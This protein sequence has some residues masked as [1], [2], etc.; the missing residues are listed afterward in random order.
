MPSNVEETDIDPEADEAVRPLN[1]VGAYIL[2]QQ[3]LAA[4]LEIERLAGGVQFRKRLHKVGV[5]VGPLQSRK[6][7]RQHIGGHDLIPTL[8]EDP[9]P[10]LLA[11]PH[12][13]HQE[14]V[15]AFAL[16]LVAFHHHQ[17][18]RAFAILKFRDMTQGGKAGHLLSRQK[19]S[20]APMCFSITAVISSLSGIS[21][22]S[23]NS[24]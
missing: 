13:A 18:H 19:H 6:R 7:R 2:R 17:L 11:V 10:V 21:T 1:L 8:P 12:L 22:G 20:T 3:E 24:I 16:E 14:G 23:L 4:V 5:Q 9:L 15:K